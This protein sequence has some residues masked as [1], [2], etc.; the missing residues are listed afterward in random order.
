MSIRTVLLATLLTLA[1]AIASADRGDNAPRHM[2]M[3]Q[4]RRQA[5]A[6]RRV[7][8]FERLI[9]RLDQD[10]DGRLSAAEV[11]D[12]FARFQRFDANGDGWITLDE[13][14]RARP[15]AA[16]PAR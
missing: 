2:K 6:F 12:R 3:K 13:V 7:R 8:R 10:G 9:Q 1:P 4:L 15:R 5:R 14:M 16:A 11:G